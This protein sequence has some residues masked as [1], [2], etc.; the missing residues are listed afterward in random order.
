M[1]NLHTRTIQSSGTEIN[2][3]DNSVYGY[4]RERVLIID[5][6]AMAMALT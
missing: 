6:P 2:N 3:I 1:Y 5:P 4:Y